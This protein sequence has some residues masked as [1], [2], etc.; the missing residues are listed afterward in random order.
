M[1]RDDLYAKHMI[2]IRK[3][4][5]WIKRGDGMSKR[6]KLRQAHIPKILVNQW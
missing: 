2:R 3:T 1:Q 5:Q 6:I 4:F